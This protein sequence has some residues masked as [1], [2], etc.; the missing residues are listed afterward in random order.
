MVALRDLN[1]F[2]CMNLLRLPIYFEEHKYLEVLTSSKCK[3][4]VNFPQGSHHLKC[5][6]GLE[7]VLGDNKLEELSGDFHFLKSK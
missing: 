2:I 3:G 1:M 6:D 7:Y 4:L 5:L